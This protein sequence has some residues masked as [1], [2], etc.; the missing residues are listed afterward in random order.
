MRGLRQRILELEKNGR[1]NPKPTAPVVTA[2]ASK[3]MSYSEDDLREGIGRGPDAAA[4]A[5]KG[6][7]SVSK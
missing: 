6:G 7:Y 1:R 4:I 2:L 5:A 3:P